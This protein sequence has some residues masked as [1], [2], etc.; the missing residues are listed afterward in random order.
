MKPKPTS[1]ITL[2]AKENPGKRFFAN[3]DYPLISEV[4]KNPEYW[5]RQG[6]KISDTERAVRRIK[7]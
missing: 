5:A 6:W 7:P 1:I 3:P 4:R 2:W